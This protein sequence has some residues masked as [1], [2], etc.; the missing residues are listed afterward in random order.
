MQVYATEWQQ[1][2]CVLNLYSQKQVWVQPTVPHTVIKAMLQNELRQ[3][4]LY[5]L[6]LGKPVSYDFLQVQGSQQWTNVGVANGSP[7]V[8]MEH[9]H[10]V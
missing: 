8:C 10:T 2:A 4:M 6:S 5:N 1:A 9:V 3:C 7:T